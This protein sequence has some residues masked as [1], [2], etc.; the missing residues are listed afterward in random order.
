[1]AHTQKEGS[2]CQKT[3][4]VKATSQN[5]VQLSFETMSNGWGVRVRRNGQKVGEL[6]STGTLK[7]FTR[8]RPQTSLKKSGRE[9]FVKSP[10]PSPAKGLI[11]TGRRPARQRERAVAEELAGYGKVA[12]G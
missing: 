5:R 3:E 12:Q 6:P 11:Y 2:E 9:P 10:R 7:L 4:P 1:M 8:I